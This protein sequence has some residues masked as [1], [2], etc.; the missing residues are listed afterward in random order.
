[1]SACNR[2]TDQQLRTETLEDNVTWLKAYAA[3]LF[4]VLHAGAAYIMLI[5]WLAHQ[6]H[7]HFHNYQMDRRS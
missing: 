3:T 6:L 2:H 1:M 5:T 7:R 4:L